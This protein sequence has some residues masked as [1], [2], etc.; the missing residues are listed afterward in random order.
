MN[1]KDLSFTAI[2]ICIA[3]ICAVK[4]I[5]LHNTSNES[6][7]D[8][9]DS[10]S[11]VYDHNY[12]SFVSTGKV[13]CT[14]T[15]ASFN[16]GVCY[17]CPVGFVLNSSLQCIGTQNASLS[18]KCDDPSSVLLNNTCL[19][20]PIGQRFNKST[21]TCEANT[22]KST[23]MYTCLKDRDYLFDKTCYNCA[24]KNGTLNPKTLMCEN[25]KNAYPSTTYETDKETKC[26]D[27]YARKDNTCYKCNAN[28]VYI[29]GMC[30][31]IDTKKP[32]FSYPAKTDN[33]LFPFI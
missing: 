2:L 10:D 14:Y 30:K 6:D 26:K 8:D 3:L 17:S 33:I 11:D 24:D 23:P 9:I 28:D 21:N 22:E 27:G 29:D 18:M 13:E 20:C 16:N 25:I 7:S 12:D 19:G 32:T 31:T 5:E 4:I 15:N 1:T